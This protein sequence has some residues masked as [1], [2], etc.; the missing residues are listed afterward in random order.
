MKRA[1]SNEMKALEDKLPL[2]ELHRRNA[3]AKRNGMSLTY[4]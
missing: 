4:C 2:W 1:C 3:L